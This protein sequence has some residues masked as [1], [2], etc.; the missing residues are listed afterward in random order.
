MLRIAIIGSGFGRYG[1]LPAFS[2]IDGCTVVA[3]CGNMDANM[4]ADCKRFGVEKIY[5]DWKELLA[6]EDL[7]AVALAVTPRAQYM[8]AKA[9]IKAGLH[10]FAE[11]PLTANLAQ[12]KELLVLAKKKRIVHGVD[13]LFPE[14]NAWKYVKDLLVGKTYGELRHISAKWDFLSYDIKNKKKSWKTTSAEGGGA[15]SFYFSHG[16]YY[17]EHFAG[18]ISDLKCVFTY[19][20][21]SLGGAESGVDM[22]FKYKNGVTGSAHMS[23][24]T[25]GIHRHRVTFQCAEALIVL[26]NANSHVDD[27]TVTIYGEK[28]AV[29]ADVAAE[30]RVEGQDGRVAI[31]QKVA[32]RFVES[33]VKHSS[34]SPSFIDGVRVQELIEKIRSNAKHR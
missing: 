26:E 11:K 8:I 2:G 30:N 10:V 17:L 32:R 13:F 20:K 1:L 7:D 5:T 9:A 12:A 14:I 19:A 29:F 21:E 16:L 28:G 34:M 25:R 4:I 27:F 3:M 15:L 23:C 24:N 31:V 33:C 6:N 22:V 18:K